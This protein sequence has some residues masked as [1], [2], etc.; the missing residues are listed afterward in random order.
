ML[1]DTFRLSLEPL[2]NYDPR[3]G[4]LGY[5]PVATLR[6]QKRSA[7]GDGGT[8]G[9]GVGGEEWFCLECVES[10]L[11]GFCLPNSRIEI[12]WMHDSFHSVFAVANY[13]IADM[14]ECID[15]PGCF[16]MHQALQYALELW[17]AVKLRDE[18]LL[19]PDINYSGPTPM[20]KEPD[21]WYRGAD[22]ET[23][24]VDREMAA[25]N[26]KFS[27][28]SS[29]KISTADV[30][31]KSL[32]EVLEFTLGFMRSHSDRVQARV[33]AAATVQQNAQQSNDESISSG[34]LEA[35]SQSDAENHATSK[36]GSTDNDLQESNDE[37]EDEASPAIADQSEI[38]W[39]TEGEDSLP[40]P[41]QQR[42]DKRS[43]NTISSPVAALP[44]NQR[45]YESPY[46]SGGGFSARYL[47]RPDLV[48]GW[49]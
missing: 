17:K 24:Y 47:P 48:D 29:A 30:R 49:G 31:D 36:P 39:E 35:N 46:L 34:E 4:V 43:I 20:E 12:P 14:R 11:V 21:K 44:A 19:N 23:L 45:R 28:G 18:V 27:D 10:M 38:D 25:L 16:T 37:P 6:N 15:H 33:Q 41:P 26:P 3:N 1:P 9:L 42:P 7:K 2:S 8:R 5:M 13:I 32:S 22:R 40:P